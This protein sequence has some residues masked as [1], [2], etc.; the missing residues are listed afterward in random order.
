MNVTYAVRVPSIRTFTALVAGGLAAD[1]AWEFWAR[2]VTPLIV[3]G[4]L[5]PAALI[6]SLFRLPQEYF[7][8]AEVLHVITGLVFYPMVMWGI[9]TYFYAGSR[10]VDGLIIGLFTW[11]LS[12]G[13]FAPLAGLP[14]M[15]G[16]ILLA[17]MSGI[18]HVLYGI[19]LSFV[20]RA[21]ARDA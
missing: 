1:L 10:L 4:P 15:L 16:F 7:L 11:F 3:G 18:G 8:H 13:V 6:L 17:W 19:A 14:F 20:F 5:Q 21:V 12:L 9:R 2:A